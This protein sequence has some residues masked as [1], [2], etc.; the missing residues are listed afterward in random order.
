MILLLLTGH[1]DMF[2]IGNIKEKEIIFCNGC[3]LITY[4]LYR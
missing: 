4:H 2:P 1:K 3:R